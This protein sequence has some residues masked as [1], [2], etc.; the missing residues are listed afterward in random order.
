M[1]MDKN[2]NTKD[3][4]GISNSKVNM[5]VSSL[6]GGLVVNNYRELCKLLGEEIKGGNSK[7]YQMQEWER[8]FSWQKEGNKFI[9]TEI[10]NNPKDKVDLRAEGNNSIYSEEIQLMIL[11]LIARKNDEDIMLSTCK[12]LTALAMINERYSDYMDER[13]KQYLSNKLNFEEWYVTE[14][15]NNTY[16]S[17]KNALESALNKL[18]RKSLLFWTKV[19][20]LCVEEDY[21]NKNKSNKSIKI[22]YRKAT[23]SEIQMILKVEKGIMKEMGFDDKKEVFLKGKWEEFKIRVNDL[24]YEEKG[25]KYYYQSY[26]I[27]SVRDYILKELKKYDLSGARQKLNKKIKERILI[28]ANNRKTKSIE[29]VLGNPKTEKDRYRKKD[30]YIDVM[31]KL[32]EYLI[33]ITE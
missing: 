18:E 11:D 25:I 12:L 24:L 31:K 32:A 26:E 20:T 3:N 19:L 6:S 22:I 17:L 8:Y 27:I 29:G 28:N 16:S 5:N 2:K 7:K 4:V 15:Y 30:E 23:E 33:D 10:Y 21:L 1:N 9:I 14:F 13:G